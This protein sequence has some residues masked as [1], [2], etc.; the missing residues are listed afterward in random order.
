M[1]AVSFDYCKFE[2]D[3]LWKPIFWTLDASPFQ[4]GRDVMVYFHSSAH[5]PYAERRCKNVSAK[6]QQKFKEWLD[7][8]SIMAGKQCPCRTCNPV[9]TCM[10]AME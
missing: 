1:K 3:D 5:D 6:Q 2:T 9:Q 4:V 10:V 7:Y 8:S